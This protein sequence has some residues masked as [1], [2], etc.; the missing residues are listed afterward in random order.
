MQNHL[1]SKKQK[2]SAQTTPRLILTQITKIM[3]A[4]LHMSKF[5]E[6]LT[7]L[8]QHICVLTVIY[9]HLQILLAKYVG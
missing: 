8:C 9:L 6:L 2:P 1:D 3:D 5:Q 7:I 4:M